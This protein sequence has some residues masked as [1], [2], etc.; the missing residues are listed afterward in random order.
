MGYKRS[1][2]PAEGAGQTRETVTHQRAEEGVVAQQAL[3][4]GRYFGVVVGSDGFELA[5][6]GLLLWSGLAGGPLRAR[7][8]G[9]L[10]QGSDEDR[11]L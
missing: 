11:R 2:Q 7:A 8:G 5:H 1:E 4:Y 9:G 6:H 10:Q 3:Q